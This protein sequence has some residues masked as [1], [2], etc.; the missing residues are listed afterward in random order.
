MEI[1]VP[2]NV[3]SVAD[4]FKTETEANFKKLEK[5]LKDNIPLGYA[6]IKNKDYFVICRSGGGNLR[7]P[8]LSKNTVV[9]CF[10]HGTS[11]MS[12]NIKK[13]EC[14]P[15]D[16]YRICG[17]LQILLSVGFDQIPNVEIDGGSL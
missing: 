2:V 10:D 1:L 6:F 13:G 12:Y 17:L 4:Q 9:E 5:M 16:I 11:S 14:S 8:M 7:S 3:E 15:S